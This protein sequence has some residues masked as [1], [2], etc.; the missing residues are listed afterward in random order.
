MASES[1]ET[2]RFSFLG[3][4]NMG[5]PLAMNL[6]KAGEEVCVFT[7]RPDCAARFLEAGA[8]VA[9]D[10]AQLADCDALCTSLPQP[11]QI[12]AAVLG[13]KGLYGQMKPGSIHLEFST[14]DPATANMLAA[15]AAG[16]GIEYVQATVSKTPAV[17]AAGEA[18]L[19]L[20]GSEAAIRKLL[21][22]LTR[23]AKPYNLK[24]IDA[25][26]AVKLISNLVGMSNIA[27][28]AEGLRI[29]QAA[30]IDGEE[31]LELLLDTGCAS[32]QMKVRGP[33]MLA[34]D[35][36]A[37]FSIDIAAKDLRLGCA[38]AE[39]LGFEPRLMRDTLRY[40]EDGRAK[41]MGS[42]DV[43]ALYKIINTN[44]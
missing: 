3:V 4:G 17:A 23:I 13:E 8:S 36:K 7:S 19:F 20:G 1:G 9:A 21:P 43:C 11:P 44:R 16:A 33:W 22:V 30:G 5:E 6:V 38:M 15:E 28:V 31:L 41:G 42:E 29:G 24:T 12:I 35:Y 27:L 18:P 39:E 25:A 2:M 10:I 14:I 34:H 40:L 26:C 37:R 32:Y